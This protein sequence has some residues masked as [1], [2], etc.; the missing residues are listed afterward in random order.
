VIAA[1]AS[2][3]APGGRLA[4][5]ELHPDLHARGVGANF[6]IDGREVRLPSFRHDA[7]ELASAV[8]RAGLHL[9]AAADRAPTANAL[10]RSPKLARYAGQPVLLEVTA[11]RR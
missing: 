2:A 8:A 1:A 11:E 9:A 5:I 7:A 6:R 10:A 3:L 4:V